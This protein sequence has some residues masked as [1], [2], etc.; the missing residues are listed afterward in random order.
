[1]QKHS[2]IVTRRPEQR[3][4][5]GTTDSGGTKDGERGDCGRAPQDPT[6]ATQERMNAP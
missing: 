5:L 3:R 4:A 6:I 1:M 2:L